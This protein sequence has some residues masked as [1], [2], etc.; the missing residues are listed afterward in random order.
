MITEEND[1]QK[2][3]KAQSIIDSLR[4]QPELAIRNS[5]MSPDQPQLN[6]KEI[7]LQ[8]ITPSPSIMKIPSKVSSTVRT[9]R[10]SKIYKEDLDQ[11]PVKNPKFNDYRNTILERPSHYNS[12][13]MVAAEGGQ[14]IANHEEIE[15][16][17][18]QDK[19]QQRAMNC[20]APKSPP[21]VEQ[22]NTTD[23][24]T[25][26]KG[27]MLKEQEFYKALKFVQNYYLEICICLMKLGKLFFFLT[28]IYALV[29]MFWFG[30]GVG[31]C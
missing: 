12:S 29:C 20:F 5:E 26:K 1:R 17:E 2:P 15:L 30:C 10:K 18:Q 6:F 14:E 3:A 11:A 28:A 4:S 16:T 21:Q 7:E 27:Y 23:L 25:E 31:D 19:S 8:E 13:L 24:D 9:M 22:K